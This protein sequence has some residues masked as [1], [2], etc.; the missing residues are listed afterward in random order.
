VWEFDIPS[1]WH[2]IDEDSDIVRL[3]SSASLTTV[4]PV[5]R[6]G[7]AV[8]GLGF[9]LNKGLAGVSEAYKLS[10]RPSETLQ[11]AGETL[12]QQIQTITVSE[13]PIVIWIVTNG[14]DV[15]S[16][17]ATITNTLKL[18]GGAP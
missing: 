2:V 5:P 18:T 12:K 14:V 6:P 8:I 15:S 9:Y 10:H 16:Q 4:D 11:S 7:Q 17:L 13:Y 1:G 3:G